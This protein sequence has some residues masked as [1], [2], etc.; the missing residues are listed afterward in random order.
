MK[1]SIQDF[2]KNHQRELWQAGFAIAGGL[3]CLVTPLGPM[4]ASSS[5][6]S[7]LGSAATPTVTAVVTIS[8]AGAA[9]YASSAWS[10]L[11]ALGTKF[12]GFLSNLF[13]KGRKK[14]DSSD[15]EDLGEEFSN[16]EDSTQRL[17]DG[18]RGQK[19][20]FDK[21]FNSANDFEMKERAVPGNPTFN[22]APTDEEEEELTS[23]VRPS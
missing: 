20:T 18:L 23:S 1:K 5:L 2:F 11:S 9:P 16:D 12:S 17:L 22:K 7:W 13:G 3:S 19:R 8:I 4:L 6:F 14:D 21:K 10:R 15:D